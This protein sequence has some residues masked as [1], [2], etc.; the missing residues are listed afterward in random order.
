[1]VFSVDLLIDCFSLF[2]WWSCDNRGFCEEL[3]FGDCSFE[4]D[5][6]GVVRGSCLSWDCGFCIVWGRFVFMLLIVLRLFVGSSI[7]LVR[8]WGGNDGNWVVGVVGV[9]GRG[10]WGMLSF[11]RGLS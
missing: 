7:E 1:M 8:G 5:V 3:K 4:F 2:V 6:V 11:V 9:V 10:D